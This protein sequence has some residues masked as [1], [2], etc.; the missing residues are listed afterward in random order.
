MNCS[1]EI[2]RKMRSAC[3]ALGLAVSLAG[4]D[5]LLLLS[6]PAG[7][8]TADFAEGRH[9]GDW[10]RHPV[11]GDPSF[12]AFQRRPGNPIHRG[13]PP[14]EWPVNG[15]LFPDPISGH[16]YVF[17][18]DYG[19]GYLTPPS[20]CLLY[21]SADHGLS[22]TN[23]GVVLHG[24]PLMFDRGGHTPDVSVVYAD[25]RYH[26]VYDW[27][28]PDFNAEGGLAYAWA[29]RPEG[30]WHRAPQPITR[31]STLSKLF[32]RYQ[33]TYAATLLRRQHDWLIL[34]MMDRAPHSWALFA[35]T[36]PKPEGPYSD[37]RLVR[38]V[39]GDYFHPPLLEFYPAFEHNGF[40]YAPATSVA[41]NR[42]F[43]AVFRAPI[44]R[45]A[46]PSAW[47]LFQ[48]GSAWHSEDREAEHFGIWGQTFSGFVDARGTL[49]AMFPSR[50]AEGRGTIS[51]AQRPWNEPLR[52]HGFVLS[53]HQGPA[54]TLLRRA[55]D[56]FALDAALRL[57]GTLRVLLDYAAPLG[58]NTPASDATLHP[59]MNTRHWGLELTSGQWRLLRQDASGQSEILCSGP[60]EE[61]QQRTVQLRRRVGQLAIRVDGRELWAGRLPASENSGSTGVLGLRVEADSHVVVERFNVQGT[62]KP[63]RMS[64]LWTEALLGAG[65][66]P[67]D[68]AESREAGFRYASGVVSKEASARVK[69]NVVGH[70]FRLWSPRGPGYGS[71]E[72]RVDGRTAAML[73]FHAD[74]EVESQP[75]WSVKGLPDSAHAVVV[76]AKSGNIPVDSLET[77]NGPGQAKIG[78]EAR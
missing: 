46:E 8:A 6:P 2:W 28:Q 45:A 72:V 43:N 30:P 22:W 7:A 42:D 61:G 71:A 60:L 54:L 19:K 34:A 56:D 76:V 69:W 73:D 13:A 18:G 35:M 29:A 32:G 50:D 40:V 68:W 48:C 51:L 59:L 37:R 58:P 25:G 53:G 12:D 78:S 36:A 49:Q 63:A 3:R 5:A 44:E 31:N 10:L 23:L 64:F 17:V 26:M 14:F 65:E 55:Y 4:M 47:A 75:V 11:Y 67:A 62:P 52:G 57:R 27:G 21:R 16:W 38:Q 24:D 77:T 70:S 1:V 20:R 39:E 74:Q 15:F 33:R 9:A 66:S 41:L